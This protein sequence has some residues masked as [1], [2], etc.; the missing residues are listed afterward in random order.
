MTERGSVR[1]AGLRRIDL[2]G[3]DPAEL[4]AACTRAARIASDLRRTR[5]RMGRAHGVHGGC[6]GV[7]MGCA[8]GAHGG[9]MRCAGGAEE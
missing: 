4:Q 3:R 9:C 1:V 2:D 5:G 7:G 6:I 8:C